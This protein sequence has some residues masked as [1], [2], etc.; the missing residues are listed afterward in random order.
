M[1]DTNVF[2][3]FEKSGH[4][5]DFSQWSDSEF[6][7]ISVVTASELLM[8]VHRADTDQR[9]E[10]RSA[11]VEA[12]IAGCK[13]LGFRCIE[14]NTEQEFIHAIQKNPT[15]DGL[16]LVYADWLEERGDD[17]AEYLRLE[18]LI[19]S[20]PK[21]LADLGKKA[22]PSWINTVSRIKKA[23]LVSFPAENKLEVI[24]LIREW[25][26]VGLAQAKVMSESLP[27][28]IKEPVTVAAGW[29][30]CE[31]FRPYAEVAIEP[32]EWTNFTEAP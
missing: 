25:R 32:Y 19:F 26:G 6:V 8:G 30:I 28:T 5:R 20:I 29:L 13:P 24:T 31:A 18:C 7:S 14:M 9:R 2:I 3:R 17:R 22:D 4:A 11:F 23:V 27:S 15:D 1:V 21:K 12:V 16:R 10:R